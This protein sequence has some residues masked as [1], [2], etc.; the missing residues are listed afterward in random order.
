MTTPP[1]DH[2]DAP[3]RVCPLRYHHGAAALAAAPLRP[4]Q[5]LYVIGGLYGNT[6]A[7]ATIEAM[8]AAEPGPVRCC[9]NGDFHWFDADPARFDE[10][11]RG[12]MRHDATLGNVE[13]E[14]GHEGME[15]GCGCAYPAD[16]DDG[17][18]TRS[19]R[20]HARLQATARSRP[21]GQDPLPALQA[22]PMFARYQV[23]GARIGVVH[24][25]A[26]ALAGWRFDGRTLARRDRDE[27]E[28][29]ARAFDAAE[30]DLFASSHTCLP[31]L[32]AFDALGHPAAPGGA[33]AR[34]WVVN[35][36]AAGLPDLRG[37][38]AGL[39]TRIGVQPFTGEVL[40]QWALPVDG[41]A[42]WV[43]LLPV[44]HDAVAWQAEFLAQ[45]PPGSDAHQSYFG[46]LSQGPALTRA[47]L[48]DPV[49]GPGDAS[50]P[51]RNA[52][53][54]LVQAD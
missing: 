10:I 32:R 11:Q 18:V 28:W 4:A 52:G 15:A 34:R 9:F 8:A 16:V 7:L 20:I 3:G 40:A 47:Q 43:A 31:A 45:W 53:P 13:A 21:G 17:T 2:P 6:R 50:A 33:A 22:L 27:C 24:G 51:Q 42:V 25:D 26:D 1:T 41:A 44:R 12:V 38:P 46:R 54:A 5:T 37:D 35:N 14:L 23:G 29:R 48:F 39:I 36:G 19:N 49:I 30:V